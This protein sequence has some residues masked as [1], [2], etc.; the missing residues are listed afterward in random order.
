M[1]THQRLAFGP[2]RLDSTDRCLRNGSQRVALP[3]KPFRVLLHLVRNAGRL[4]TKDELLASCWPETHVCEGV[5]KTCVAEL[6][7]ALGDTA[8]EPRYIETRPRQGYRFIAS[9]SMGSLPSASTS[10]VGRGAQIADI[11]R[12]LDVSRLVMLRGP[13]GAGKTRLA[14]QVASALQAE[15][16]HGVWWVDLGS[17]RDPDLVAHAAAVSLGVRARAGLSIRDALAESLLDRTALLVLDNCEHLVGACAALVD[18]LLSTCAG[19]TI[20]ATSRE[21]LGL[22]AE[23][24]FLVPT[25][26][27]PNVPEMAGDLLAFEATQLF[28]ERASAANRSFV[29]QGHAQAISEICHR[30]DGL[31]LAIELAAVRVR[32]L[33]P[34][35]IAS[36]LRDAFRLLTLASRADVPRHQT[37]RAAL[38]W[39]HDLLTGAQRR[40]FARLSVFSGSFALGAAEHICAGPELPAAEIGDLLAQLV[41]RSLVAVASG[42]M[43]VETRYRLLE[44]IRQYANLHVDDAERL[45]LARRHALFFLRFVE[46]IGRVF[47]TSERFSCFSRIHDERENLLAALQWCS[48]DQTSHETGLRLST[49]LWLYW[50]HCGHYGEGLAW[51]ETMLSLT[52]AAAPALQADARRIV[53]ALT[54]VQGRWR[55][56]EVVLE[57]SV[58][59]WQRSSGGTDGLGRTLQLLSLAKEKRGD[60]DA[61]NVMARTS[62]DLLRATGGVS[63]AMSL[64][65]AAVHARLLGDYPAA[66]ALC[67]ESVGVLR[68]VGDS[69]ALTVPLRHLART[70]L[71]EGDV[72]TA[73]AYCVECLDHLRPLGDK[74]FVA[75]TLEVMAEIACERGDYERAAHLFGATESLWSQ[76]DGTDIEI[77]E[78]EYARRVLQIEDDLGVAAARALWAEG[79]GLSMD[80]AIDL[81]LRLT[82]ADP[83]A[84]STPDD[85]EELASAHAP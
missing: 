59:L 10:F 15:V 6:R 49:G 17:L 71:K 35:E 8:S 50:V 3:P 18:H 72:E 26:S 14:L 56:A 63:L 41:D 84:D 55:E 13:A 52:P 61:A 28:V 24:S 5:L 42:P 1:V 39:S 2:Y 33:S 64:A 70:A 74:W 66:R 16:P 51:L 57:A 60:M 45:A 9:V 65:R 58:A 30:L 48:C 76:G 7:A 22:A 53:G 31:P 23:T 38:D 78:R 20:L 79:R 82:P 27:V 46:E 68:R 29:Y 37:L 54:L 67:E 34:E 44:P 32:A 83:A 11:R 4:V 36:R 43:A 80:E 40:L 81:A 77:N 12:L 62:V 73:E 69:W 75:T 47:E 25:L 85:V 19:L 21:S